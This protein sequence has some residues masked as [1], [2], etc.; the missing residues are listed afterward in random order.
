MRVLLVVHANEFL[1]DGFGGFQDV[2]LP[3]NPARTSHP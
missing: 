1:E 2:H 3:V